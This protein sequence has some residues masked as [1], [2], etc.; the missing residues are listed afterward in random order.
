[1]TPTGTLCEPLRQ[2]TEQNI[3]PKYDQFDSAHRRDH[4]ETVI[5]KSLELA[6]NNNADINMAYTV[7]AYHD[8]GLC[9]GRERHHIVSGQM[10]MEDTTLNRWFSPSQ[11]QLMR[12]AIEDHRASSGNAPRSIYGMIVA[13]ADRD[14]EPL[15][16]I[17]RTIQY[18]LSNYPELDK[19]DQ[20][21]RALE[22]LH[23]KY[24][25]GGYLRLWLPQGKNAENLEKL[26]EIIRNK[27]E[28]R[29]IFDRI[30]HEEMTKIEMQKRGNSL[31]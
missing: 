24:A 9:E 27:T 5:E 12:D 26:R 30:H 19:E 13:E 15:K 6:K 29:K 17:R 23:E 21:R 20:W 7:A 16:I 14:I 11:L 25:E 31:S 8:I 22:H 10:M 3:L 1:M 28:L 4:A 18:G 2:Y